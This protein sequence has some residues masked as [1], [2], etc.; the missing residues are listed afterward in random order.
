[1]HVDAVYLL[2]LLE[3]VPG[4]GLSR[5]TKI[6]DG[7]YPKEAAK[8]I[9]DLALRCKGIR[10]VGQLKETLA[11]WDK[12]PLFK[13]ALKGEARIE[14]TLRRAAKLKDR[15]KARALWQRLLQ[16]YGDTCLK[17]RIEELGGRR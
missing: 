17:P 2:G 12:D 6:R 3:Q 9:K 8:Q 5:A 1:M 7:G 11:A 16:D 13:K 15:A 14:S 4:K 10:G